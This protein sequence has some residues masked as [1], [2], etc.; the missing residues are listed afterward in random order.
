[1]KLIYTCNDSYG[2]DR[3]RWPM[4]GNIDYLHFKSKGDLI[5]YINCMCIVNNGKSFSIFDKYPHS[6]AHF[7]SKFWGNGYK[8][9][10][11]TLIDDTALSDSD[12]VLRD[13]FR[14]WTGYLNDIRTMPNG[15][16][17][18]IQDEVMTE[19]KFCPPKDLIQ[20]ALVKFSISES[21]SR[22]IFDKKQVF[23]KH[24]DVL[25]QLTDE[26]SFA[27]SPHVEISR[28]GLFYVSRYTKTP[29]SIFDL[30]PLETISDC[31]AF[32]HTWVE[33]FWDKEQKD[34]DFSSIEFQLNPY[35]WC[36]LGQEIGYISVNISSKL[37]PYEKTLNNW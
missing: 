24:Q 22:M 31:F 11:S 12:L 20:H 3:W 14:N 35:E 34:V 13:R 2:A 30:K 4:D 25:K 33:Y 16:S 1:M 18:D 9:T 15:I 27:Y 26:I 17:V 5:Q 29:F 21:Y 19:R 37:K 32:A 28:H 8:Y 10:H 6:F 7:S 23:L 36:N